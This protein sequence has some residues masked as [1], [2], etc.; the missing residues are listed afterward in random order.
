MYIQVSDNSR[1]TY[2]IQVEQVKLNKEV[3]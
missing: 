2:Q 1:L 3:L